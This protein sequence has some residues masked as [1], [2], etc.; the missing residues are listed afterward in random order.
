MF[1]RLGKPIS[2][3][4]DVEIFQRRNYHRCRRWTQNGRATWQL[5]AIWIAASHSSRL[6]VHLLRTIVVCCCRRTREG[7]TIRHRF[8]AIRIAVAFTNGSEL[9]DAR[10]VPLFHL[11]AEPPDFLQQASGATFP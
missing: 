7:C 11:D 2:Y 1:L 3:L 6:A 10:C 4:F 5:F 9:A 8:A